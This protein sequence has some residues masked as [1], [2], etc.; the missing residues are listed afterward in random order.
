[1]AA[2]G[3]PHCV[4]PRRGILAIP[5]VRHLAVVLAIKLVAI[6]LI[7]SAFFSDKPTTDPTSYVFGG[8]K[9]H[10]TSAAATSLKE[11]L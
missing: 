10:Q 2:K 1:M 5:L 11:K 3:F 6:F 4:I 9:A 8:A 7:K